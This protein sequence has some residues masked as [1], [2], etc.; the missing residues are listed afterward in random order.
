MSSSFVPRVRAL[1]ALAPALA[2]ALFMPRALLAETPQEL[3]RQGD[4]LFASARY[5]EALS[6]FEKARAGDPGN[7]EILRRVARSR[8]ATWDAFSD[9][10]S[11]R[12]VLETAAGE[13]REILAKDPDD[14]EAL[15]RLVRGWIELRKTEEAYLF[16]KGRNAK[17]PEETLTIA[18]LV[19]V[20]GMKGNAE[21]GLS[22]LRRYIALAPDDPVPHYLLGTTAWERSYNTGAGMEPGLRRKLLADGQAELDRAIALDPEYWEAMIYKN[23]M[24]REEAKIEPDASKQ[25]ALTEK[26]AEW[27]KKAL[28]IRQ[29]VGS[30]PPHPLVASPPPPPPPRKTA[31]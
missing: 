27:Q 13:Y 8:W 12:K 16:L 25:V 14:E 4:A 10:P 15:D 9:D 21:E 20:C 26:A 17:R 3:V 23:L 29:R 30:R 6:A 1:F 7:V 31:K 24:L 22:W 11:N 18:Y 28:E 2:L 5:R 19:R